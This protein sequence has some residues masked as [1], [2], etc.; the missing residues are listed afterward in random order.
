V[1]SL[2]STISSVGALAG[3]ALT[4]P[5]VW[6]AGI[7]GAIVIAGVAVCLSAVPVL[8]LLVRPTLPASDAL[9]DAGETVA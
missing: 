5:L 3:L 4:G 7:R 2:I 6:A 9:A 8:L 1:L